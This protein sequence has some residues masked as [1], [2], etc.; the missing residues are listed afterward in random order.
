[1]ADEYKDKLRTTILTDAGRQTFL[2]VGY[3]TGTLV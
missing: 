3:G 2:Q 1:M